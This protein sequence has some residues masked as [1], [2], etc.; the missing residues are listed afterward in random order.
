MD[1]VSDDRTL[2]SEVWAHVVKFIHCLGHLKHLSL[3][4]KLFYGLVYRKMWK[5][6]K[7][8]QATGLE[9][10]A[11]LPIYDLSLENKICRPVDLCTI[12]KITTLKKLNI[13]ENCQGFME[14]GQTGLGVLSTLI[15]LQCLDISR[16]IRIKSTDITAIADLPIV[17]LHITSCGVDDEC[18]LALSKMELLEELALGANP[19]SDPGM[20]HISNLTKLRCLDIS[21]CVNVSSVGVRSIMNLNIVELNAYVVFDDAGLAII[22]HMKSLQVLNIGGSE[23]I[24][25]VGI[26]HIIHLSKQLRAFDIRDCRKVTSN[27]LAHIASFTSLEKLDISWNKVDNHALTHLLDLPLVELNV[28]YCHSDDTWL[29]VISYMKNLRKLHTSNSAGITDEGLKHL[30]RLAKL[31]DLDV[32]RC[33]RISSEGLEHFTNRSVTVRSTRYFE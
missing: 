11:H 29:D 12:G 19:F 9:I 4:S 16:C 8:Q 18:M 3:V 15:H 10:I 31:Q 17:E 22:D 32:R 6:V 13:A 33:V 5:S 14:S 20:A 25:D 1:T 26:R 23:H 2:P 30:T 7:L 24:T 27:A 28:S 21:C